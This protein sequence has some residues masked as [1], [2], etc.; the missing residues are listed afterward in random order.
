ME[1]L[2]EFG[3]WSLHSIEHKYHIHQFMN[4]YG[5][6]SKRTQ[7]KAVQ[8][9]KKLEL[10]VRLRVRLWRKR[11]SYPRLIMAEVLILR[12]SIFPYLVNI[13]LIKN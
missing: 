4:N 10:V 11:F 12:N 5:F 3:V 2:G 7:E 1:G 13:A 9:Q 6:I 8:K